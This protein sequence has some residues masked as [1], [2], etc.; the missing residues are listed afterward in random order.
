MVEAA[1]GAGDVHMG[2][3]DE[4]R[5]KNR[6]REDKT[7]TQRD[8]RFSRTEQVVVRPDPGA[9]HDE[10]IEYLM[11]GQGMTLRFLS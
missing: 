2:S 11:S 10:T 6:D 9:C 7:I 5:E 8:G 1:R 4:F 3:V